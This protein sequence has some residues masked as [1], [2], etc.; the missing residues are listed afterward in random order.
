MREF[1]WMLLVL[2]VFGGACQDQP[3]VQEPSLQSEMVVGSAEE[4]KTV[5]A[6]KIIWKKDGAKMILI[7]YAFPVGEEKYDRT[8]LPINPVFYMDRT[9]VTVGR[10]KQFLAETNHSF[11]ADLWG[12]IYKYSPT[13]KHPMIYADW[14]DA[15]AYAKWAGKRLPTEEEWEFAARGGLKNKKYPWG[16]NES[17]ARDH[18]NYGDTGG[19]DKWEYCAPVGSFKPNGYSLFDMAGNVWE[20]CQDWYDS[21]R[22]EK[23]LRGGYW[24]SNS[25]TLR[26]ANR[27]ANLPTLRTHYG[28][29]RCVA[30]LP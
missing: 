25:T 4:L 6:K 5:S 1:S 13:E 8:G 18:A 22:R 3:K 2:L 17:L 26:L 20:W 11:D 27:N 21:D 29:F 9:E 10:F 7:P 12:R 15:T 19:K 14:F 28:G 24:N 30:D 16:V 23:V